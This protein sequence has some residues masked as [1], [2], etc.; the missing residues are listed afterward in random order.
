MDAIRH[1]NIEEALK[2]KTERREFSVHFRVNLRAMS[3]FA[4]VLRPSA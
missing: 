1:K 2:I 4:K 3:L